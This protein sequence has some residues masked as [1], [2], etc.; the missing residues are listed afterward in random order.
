MSRDKHIRLGLIGYG[1][2]AHEIAQKI[3]DIASIEIVGALVLPEDQSKAASFPLVTTWDELSAF[4]PTFIAECAGHKAVNDHAEA[5]LAANMDLMIISIGALADE[6]LERRIRSAAEKSS[7][8]VILPPGA[9]IG[10]DGLAAARLVGLDDVL[11][12]STKPP[13]AWAGAPGSKAINLQE[14]DRETVIFSG[15][16]RQAAQ[17]FPKNANVAATIALAGIGFDRT[18]VTLIAD[19]K[20][21]GNRHVLEFSGAAG[22][23][24]VQTDGV[25][26]PD[27][28]K[29]SMLTAY[30]ILRAIVMRNAALVI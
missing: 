10:I 20:A 25:V 4:N 7:G 1:A 28:P 15:T 29:T 19:P 9:M 30:S 13:L 5:I 21:Q 18:Q 24:L 23:Y 17:Q 12:T 16:A 26:S 8:Q 6:A 11:L 22:S 14:I 3:S 27:N 2:I